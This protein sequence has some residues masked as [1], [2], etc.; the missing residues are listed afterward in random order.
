MALTEL[1]LPTLEKLKHSLIVIATEDKRRMLRITEV[2]EFLNTMDAADLDTLLVP[3]AI[4]DELVDLRTALNEKISLFNGNAVTPTVNH[5]LVI[6]TVSY[7][8]LTLP[9]ILLV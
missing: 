6:D 4:R 2:V 7:T 8:H 3:Q 5:R 9:T 1:Q